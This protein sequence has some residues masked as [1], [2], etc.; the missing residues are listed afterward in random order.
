[1]IISKKTTGI[2]SPPYMN[3]VCIDLIRFIVT[4]WRRQCRDVG[5][6]RDLAIPCG[7][8]NVLLR[9]AL[10]EGVFEELPVLWAALVVLC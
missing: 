10:D 2:T 4:R 6:T 5:G 1:M 3:Y 9:V 8:V 7:D